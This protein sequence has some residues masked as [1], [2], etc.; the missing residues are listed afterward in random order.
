MDVNKY[1]KFL[2][3][4]D[5]KGQGHYDISWLKKPTIDNDFLCS[6]LSPLNH[7]SWCL[8]NNKNDPFQTIGQSEENNPVQL[9]CLHFS[10]NW[11]KTLPVSSTNLTVWIPIKMPCPFNI[12]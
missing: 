7:P 5:V 4:Y 3:W 2:I 10:S 8:D 11:F 9:R 12:R 6:V 1:N